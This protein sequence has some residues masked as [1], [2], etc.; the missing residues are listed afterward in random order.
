MIRFMER[1]GPE[2]CQMLKGECTGE[3]CDL[4]QTI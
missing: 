2:F 1:Q 4:M 3:V